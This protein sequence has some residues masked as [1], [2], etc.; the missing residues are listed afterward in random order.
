MPFTYSSALRPSFAQAIAPT[1]RVLLVLARCLLRSLAPLAL[2]IASFASP[3]L[4]SPR[5]PSPPRLA[6]PGPPG[7]PG[8]AGSL[9]TRA[10]AYLRARPRH[11]ACGLRGWCAERCDDRRRRRR[12]ERRR[13]RGREARRARTFPSLRILLR[14]RRPPLVVVCAATNRVAPCNK[15]CCAV[16]QIV[17]RRV[18]PCCGTPDAVPPPRQP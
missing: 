11:R 1:Q 13:R 8:G 5:L 12:V 18:A 17:L 14:A 6:S 4:P 16:Q 15:S 9:T 7:P 2:L 10:P 3:R